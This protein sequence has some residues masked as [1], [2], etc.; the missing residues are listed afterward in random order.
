M[1]KLKKEGKTIEKYE[2]SCDMGLD[3]STSVVGGAILT[4]DGKIRKLFHAKLNTVKLTN[5]F[6]K[7]DYSLERIKEEVQDLETLEEIEETED[8][9]KIF[10]YK[11]RRIFV[12]ANAKMYAAGFSSADVLLTLAKMNGILSYIC[13]KH[14]GLPVFNISVTTARSKIGFKQNKGDK[15][16]VKDQVRNWVLATIPSIPLKQHIAKTGYHKGKLVLDAEMYDEIDAWVI[17]RGGQL[18]TSL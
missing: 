6:E 8:T 14:F 10:T 15:Q 9:R 18:T 12:E 4:I 17:C 7:A 3:I 11:V 5:M 2:I 13:W 1:S 16:S